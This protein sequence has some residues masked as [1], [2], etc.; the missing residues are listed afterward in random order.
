MAHSEFSMWG[1][2]LGGNTQRYYHRA[3]CRVQ[4]RL[5][6]IVLL[7]L[8]ALSVHECEYV[9]AWAGQWFSNLFCRATIYR[10][11]K[12]QRSR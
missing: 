10:P 11:N 7:N 1:E 5:R 8:P 9:N 12:D 2:G 4:L 6:R 3:L